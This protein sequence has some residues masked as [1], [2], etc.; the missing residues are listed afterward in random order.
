[1]DLGFFK[2]CLSVRQS[3]FPRKMIFSAQI[4]SEDF[5]GT[6]ISNLNICFVRL[7]FCHASKCVNVVFKFSCFT[8]FFCIF[9]LCKEQMIKTDHLLL[10]LLCLLVKTMIFFSSEATL[11]FVYVLSPL[12]SRSLSFS[13]SLSLSFFLLFFIFLSLS[14]S[15]SLSLS[16]FLSISFSSL[17]LSLFFSFFLSLSFSLSLSLSFYLLFFPL[18]LSFSF[19]PLSLSLSPFISL[20]ISLS[21]PLLFLSLSFSFLYFLVAKLLYNL[22]TY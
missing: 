18:S 4:L 8:C 14:Y 6:C 11:Q 20:L 12:L 16:L 5:Y 19:S 17:S 9:S 15:L 1:M 13:F 3:V 7:S 10:N 2:L 22:F 21:S